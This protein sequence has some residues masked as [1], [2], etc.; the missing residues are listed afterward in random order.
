MPQF[1]W[2][3]EPTDLI[4]PFEVRYNAPDAGALFAWASKAVE[5]IYYLNDIDLTFE[6]S[7]QTI[8]NHNPDVVDL[9][10]ARWATG[11][12]ITA[13]D[14]CAAAFG[15]TFCGHTSNREMDMSFFDKAGRY[16]QEATQRRKQL[17]ATALAWIDGVLIDTEY[18][19]TKSA[20]NWL[21]HSRVTRHFK[22]GPDSR[23]R[24]RLSIDG[25]KIP[26][27]QVIETAR[28]VAVH[29]I[30]AVLKVLPT[31]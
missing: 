16:K 24:L 3:T 8:G 31:L 26:V 20:R 14:L 13:L 19:Q 15:R 12:C 17:P 21:T 9:A 4:R 27:R 7:G 1:Q 23:Q 29:H 11:T 18:M 22:L 2:S 5:E 28:G 30:S 6:A 25:H 10:H